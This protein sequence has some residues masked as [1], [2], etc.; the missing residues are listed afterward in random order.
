MADVN[1]AGFFVHQEELKLGLKQGTTLLS[2][3]REQAAK[4]DNHKLSPDEMENQTTVERLVPCC[5]YE[6]HTALQVLWLLTLLLWAS[7]SWLSWMRQRTRL[8]SSGP[9]TT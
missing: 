7:G 5:D 8:N 2:C 9:N 6:E 3:I 4:S 1:V